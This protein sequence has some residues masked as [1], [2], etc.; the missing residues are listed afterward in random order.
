[1]SSIEH[2]FVYIFTKVCIREG[3]IVAKLLFCEV[4]AL[5]ALVFSFTLFSLL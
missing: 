2:S 5:F 1:M 3:E 4:V